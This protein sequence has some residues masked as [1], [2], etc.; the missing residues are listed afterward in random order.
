MTWDSYFYN[1]CKAVALNCKCRSRQIGAILVRDRSV[2]AT[3]YNGPARGIKEC[4]LTCPRKGL[5]FKSGEGLD[6]CPA[7]HAEV[8]AV[9]DAARKGASTLGSILYMNALLPCKNCAGV[10]INAGIK[11]IVVEDIIS[12]DSL[13]KDMLEEANITIRKFK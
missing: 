11:E 2:I 13:A 10:L 3:G 1:L 9:I 12:Y 7:V 8:N 5:G 4:G 6:L